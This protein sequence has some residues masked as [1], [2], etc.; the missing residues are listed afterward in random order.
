MT[1]HLTPAAYG[2]GKT[3]P[4]RMT[5]SSWCS[6]RCTAFP[7]PPGDF[8]GRR[9]LHTGTWPLGTTSTR[10]SVLQQLGNVLRCSSPPCFPTIET[11]SA[12]ALGRRVKTTSPWAESTLLF[13]RY[14]SGCGATHPH[15]Q[16]FTKNSAASV[17]THPDEIPFRFP[18]SANLVKSILFVV[19]VIHPLSRYRS[20]YPG[21]SIGAP[22]SHT[23][24]LKRV[25]SARPNGSP[26]P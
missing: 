5:R 25:P 23:L 7:P 20:R 16:P 26:H 1:F 6:T 17:A 22:R 10:F 4:V 11:P 21:L 9:N 3:I 15:Y 13:P 24:H 19:P 8:V 14:W 12:R 2:T 18:L